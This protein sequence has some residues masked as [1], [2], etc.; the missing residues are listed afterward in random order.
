[1]GGHT[2]DCVHLGIEV[3]PASESFNSE[4]MLGDLTILTLE[5]LLTDELQHL[6]EI[7]GAAQHSGS[8]QPIEFFVLTLPRVEIG[9]H[10]SGAPRLILYER[11]S[12]GT[13]GRHHSAIHLP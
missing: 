6:G 3:A 10:L 7:M 11:L 2:D 4:H 1:M 9:G 8:Q 5:M 12:A 13:P